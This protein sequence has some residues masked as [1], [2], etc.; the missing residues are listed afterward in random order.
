[1]SGRRALVTGASRG[2]GQAIARRLQADGV[3]VLTPTHAELD[4]ASDRSIDEY[5]RQL[6]GSVHILVNNAGIN[7]LAEI[8]A[9]QDEKLAETL[10]VDLAA[11]LRLVRGVLPL[12]PRGKDCRILNISSVW[13]VVAKPGRG[14]YAAAKAGLNALTRTLALELAGEG[15]LA[16]SLSPGFVDTE[17]TRRNIPPAQLTALCAQIPLGRLATVDEIAELAAFLCSPRNTYL[18]GQNLIIDGGYTCQ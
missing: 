10:Q 11:P 4:L 6:T 3:E 9:V 8:R 13:S 14:V 7:P 12:M 15:I 17:L 18:T 16:N 5:L 2:I 1:M